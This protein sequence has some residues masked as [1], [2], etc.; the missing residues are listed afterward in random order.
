MKNH[1]P[2]CCKISVCR[3]CASECLLRS[4]SS[5]L[6][7]SQKHAAGWVLHNTGK[8]NILF[9]QVPG[10]HLPLPKI[11][12]KNAILETVPSF[13]YLCIHL[14]TNI[15]INDEMRHQIAR[16][17]AAFG[18]LMTLPPGPEWMCTAQWSSLPCYTVQKLGLHINKHIK[19]LERFYQ[20]C[21]RKILNI[22]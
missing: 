7:C 17:S 3:W 10:V 19:S 13:P 12:A 2:F 8:T 15:L 21:L 18:T 1:N 5:S 14:S 11:T 6:T 4:S 16:A 20:C 22:S 9:Q